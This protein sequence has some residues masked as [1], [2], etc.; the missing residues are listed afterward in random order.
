M[1]HSVKRRTRSIG[2]QPLTRK[3]VP[4]ACDIRSKTI[5]PP[6]HMSWAVLMRV[7]A[8]DFVMPTTLLPQSAGFCNQ[9]R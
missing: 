1:S 3:H 7:L 8:R 2:V 9:V 4:Q 6:D 5:A